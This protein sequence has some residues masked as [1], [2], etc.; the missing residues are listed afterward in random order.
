LFIKLTEENNKV[1]AHSI[2]WLLGKVSEVIPQI[3]K[4]ETLY[5]LIP[6]LINSILNLDDNVCYSIEIRI[7]LAMVFGNVIKYYGDE[8]TQ[9]YNNIFSPYYKL[10]LNRFIN[11]SVIEEN[12]KMNLSFYL[13]RIIIMAIQYSS[14]DFQDSIEIYL[15]A[16]VD[17]LESIININTN[18]NY[19][20]YI[21]IEEYLC[22]VINHIFHK[23]RR[24]VNIE[25]CKRIYKLI[26]Q[27]FTKHQHISESG[28]IIIYNIII[29]LYHTHNTLTQNDNILLRNLN[30]TPITLL[31][32]FNIDD[33][34]TYILHSIHI[35]PHINQP[36]S[37]TERALLMQS[38][39]L[40]ITKLSSYKSPLIQTY[41]KDIIQCI[42][43]IMVNPNEF[44]EAKG[45]VV[46]DNDEMDTIKEKKYIRIEFEFQRNLMLVIG[47][48][49][50]NMKEDEYKYKDLFVR[51]ITVLMYSQIKTK[52]NQYKVRCVSEKEGVIEGKV[53]LNKDNDSIEIDMHNIFSKGIKIT[54]I[55]SMQLL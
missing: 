39:L 21:N 38:A 41:S 14:N 36:N 8:C 50:N 3:F 33:S 24:D 17:K 22:L 35:S 48:E 16:I 26:I 9:K 15:T 29:T 5:T 45:V 31:D 54:E 42:I 51:K 55:I 44:D 25:L 28:M 27:S 10:F 53:R 32:Q 13:I 52:I 34:F 20:L 1:I 46:Y 11:E 30:N 2:G 37:E 23:I 4:K 49:M 40:I 6:K 19:N 7:N 43:D 47:K 18:T 12:V